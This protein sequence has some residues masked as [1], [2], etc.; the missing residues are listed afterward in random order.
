MPH[1]LHSKPLKMNST[2]ITKWEEEN[3]ERALARSLDALKKKCLTLY[4]KYSNQRF[5]RLEII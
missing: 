3:S 2:K 4:Q 5:Y 1:K